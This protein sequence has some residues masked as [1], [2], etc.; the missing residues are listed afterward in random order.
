MSESTDSEMYQAAQ[1][2]KT[3]LAEAYGKLHGAQIFVGK[4]IQ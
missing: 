1:Q 4:R 2:M 3:I